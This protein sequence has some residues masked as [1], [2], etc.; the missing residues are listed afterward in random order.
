MVWKPPFLS[1]ARRGTSAPAIMGDAEARTV[2]AELVVWADDD[3]EV[4]T[5]EAVAVD[6]AADARDMTA[7]EAV[8]Q[9]A[10]EG[11]V[12]V[13]SRNSRTGY[14]GVHF[15]NRDK[16][17]KYRYSVYLEGATSGLYT[18]V[19]PTFL[20]S[21]AT[22]EQAALVYARRTDNRTERI[23]A[24]IGRAEGTLKALAEA[25]S[26]TV[27]CR[28]C[29]ALVDLQ[30]AR[31]GK[32][33]GAPFAMGDGCF[34]CSSNS[35]P[36]R[37]RKRQTSMAQAVQL[38]KRT[39]VAWPKTS[40]S[41]VAVQAL[42][43]EEAAAM[44]RAALDALVPEESRILNSA[45]RAPSSQRLE[46]TQETPARRSQRSGKARALWL[47]VEEPASDDEEYRLV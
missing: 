26:H 40:E 6:A 4:L 44:V 45:S 13:K 1:P 30:V 27:V 7:E 11:L 32:R 9:A 24:D 14:F 42:P 21:F 19:R 22:A 25:S 18:K 5:V 47:E 12:L 17:L 33:A 28:R 36:G 37:L 43:P 34:R 38:G 20:G 3:S 46:E 2:V 29:Q 31:R 23:I 39:L 16:N 8:A 41:R 15:D 10:R 35:R